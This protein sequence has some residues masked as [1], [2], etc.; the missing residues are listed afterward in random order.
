LFDPTVAWTNI[1]ES[2]HE[3]MVK[4]DVF[5][6]NYIE[7]DL[8]SSPGPCEKAIQ[9]FPAGV[10]IFCYYSSEKSACEMEGYRSYYPTYY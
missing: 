9:F 1:A 5:G 10:E 7:N 6:N 2:Q 8:T 4:M 3:P